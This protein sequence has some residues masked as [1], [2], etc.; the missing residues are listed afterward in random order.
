[1]YKHKSFHQIFTIK[2]RTQTVI[3]LI[4]VIKIFLI[5]QCKK[6]TDKTAHALWDVCYIFNYF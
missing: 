5:F 3:R 6:K 2:I 4:F 1:M